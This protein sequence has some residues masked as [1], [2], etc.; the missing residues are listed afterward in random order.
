MYPVP[1]IKQTDDSSYFLDFRYIPYE[2]FGISTTE[3]EHDLTK[4]NL[5]ARNFR[6]MQTLPALH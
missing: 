6:L 1:T 3:L 5:H 2:D 4:K